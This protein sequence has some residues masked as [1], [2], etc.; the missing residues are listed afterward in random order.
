MKPPVPGETVVAPTGT[1]AGPSLQSGQAY[2]MEI[3]P[4]L[5]G[6]TLLQYIGS[7]TVPP[8]AE[9][10]VWF[11]MRQA[12]GAS[13]EQIRRFHDLIFNQTQL[14]GNYRSVMPLR[15]RKVT[16]VTA[17]LIDKTTPEPDVE[18]ALGPN[19][20]LIPPSEAVRIAEEAA[21]ESQK[22]TDHMADLDKR[23]HLATANHA[24]AL[25]PKVYEMMVEPTEAPLKGKLDPEKMVKINEKFAKTIN[26]AA[27]DAVK[28][29]MES[30]IDG[31]MRF[32]ATAAG[33]AGE[34]MR[35]KYVE[36]VEEVKRI[37]RE[38]ILESR[39]WRKENATY[40]NEVVYTRMKN[41]AEWEKFLESAKK[42]GANGSNWTNVSLDNMTAFSAA[43][44]PAPSAEAADEEGEDEEGEDEEEE[45]EDAEE[46]DAADEEE[47]E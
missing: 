37:Q 34:D 21:R 12:L 24:K 8:C 2:G 44:A 18:I 3:S 26:N 22:A 45:G 10:N 27:T 14:Y 30:I 1:W 25:D 42:A 47:G 36:R 13:N 29:G 15:G 32:T 20:K 6:G 28:S 46:E 33:S 9:G 40:H 4:L 38:Q 17:T 31:V 16:A 5:Y 11:V 23:L 7:G 19:P 39:R 35:K 41:R 43:V